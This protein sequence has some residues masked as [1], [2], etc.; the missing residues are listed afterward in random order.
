MPRPIIAAAVA[1]LLCIAPALADELKVDGSTP[2]TTSA[3]LHAIY[4]QHSHRETCLLQSALINIAVGEKDNRVAKGESQDA[5][6]PAVGTFING[7]TYDGIIDKSHDYPSK[8][9]ALCRD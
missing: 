4:A 9:M 2:D 1:C 3:S 8:V 7:L 6:A 5:P